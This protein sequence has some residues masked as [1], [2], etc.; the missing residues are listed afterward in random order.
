[1]AGER[2]VIARRLSRRSR[3]AAKADDVHAGVL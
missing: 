2:A 1:L 3:E